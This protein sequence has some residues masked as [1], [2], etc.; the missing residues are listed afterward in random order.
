VGQGKEA[1]PWEES[2]ISMHKPRGLWQ[3]TGARVGML[4]LPRPPRNKAL[5]HRTTTC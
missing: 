4:V 2:S 3:E 5:V 1:D